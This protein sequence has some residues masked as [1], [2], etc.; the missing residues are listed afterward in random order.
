MKNKLKIIT[1]LMNASKEL[2]D[3]S[4]FAALKLFDAIQKENEALGIAFECAYQNITLEQKNNFFRNLFIYSTDE[5]EQIKLLKLVCTKFNGGNELSD[6]DNV[7]NSTL[8]TS[9]CL[10]DMLIS[11][12]ENFSKANISVEGSEKLS[13][14]INVLRDTAIDAIMYILAETDT[15]YTLRFINELYDF[16]DNEVAVVIFDEFFNA[17]HSLGDCAEEKDFEFLVSSFSEDLLKFMSDSYGKED[18]N[19]IYPACKSLIEFYLSKHDKY[20]YFVALFDFATKNTSNNE[21]SIIHSVL[22]GMHETMNFLTEF[23]ITVLIDIITKTDV[24]KLTTPEDIYE[25]YIKDL[26]LSQIATAAKV[27]LDIDILTK[28]VCIK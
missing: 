22:N 20:E 2:N 16:K 24:K 21:Y 15:H 10:I 23:G 7:S 8:I 11:F 28:Y 9:S 19:K 18:I 13:E 12:M 5:E 14:V 25:K 26:N 1:N 17:I 3:F 27:N 4:Y 6:K